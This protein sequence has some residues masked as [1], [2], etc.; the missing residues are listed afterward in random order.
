MGCCGEDNR[1][2]DTTNGFRKT[3]RPRE[4]TDVFWL[5]LFV[6]FWIGLICIATF[7]YIIGNPLRLYY[8]QDSFGNICGIRNNLK[9]VDADV[10]YSGMDMTRRPFVF[11]MDPHNISHSLK[12]CV[13]SCPKETLTSEA[14]LIR[15]EGAYN[16]SYCRYD[17]RYDPNSRPLVVPTPY[18]SP[19]STP[20]DLLK[21]DRDQGYGP[22]PRLPVYES[23]PILKRCIPT[24]FVALGKNFAQGVYAYLNSFDTLKQVVGDLVASQDEIILM[25]VVATIISFLA[26]FMIHLVASLVSYFI[27]LFVSFSLTAV[28]SMLW[29][30]YYDI[31]YPNLTGKP[32]DFL[33]DTVR[34]EKTFLWMSIGSTVITIVL[35]LLCFVMRKRVKLVV[36]LF[37]E[38]GACIRA[39]PAI[40]IQPLWTLFCLIVFLAFWGLVLVSLATADHPGTHDVRL[41]VNARRP[42]SSS[43]T[44]GPSDPQA[45]LYGQA[46]LSILKRV[47][48]DHPSWVTYMWWYL[49]IALF[50]NCEFILSCQQMVIAGA[51]A[52]WYFSR[53]RKNLSCPVGGAIRRLVRYHIGS[54]ALGSFLI[55]LLKL[56]RY[57][58][59][60]IDA[61]LK[62]H[63]EYFLVKGCL[64]C[65]SCCLW[66]VEKFIKYLN[67]NAYT[68]IAIEGSNFCA[69]TQVAFQTIVSNALRVATI[70]SVGDFIL[71]LGKCGVTALTAAIGTYVFKQ[72]D[73]LEF[74]AAPVILTSIVAY[75]IAHSIFSIY[76]MVID[77][78]FLCFC[79]DYNKNDGSPGKEYYAPPSLMAFMTET[80]ANE[81]IA[82][83]DM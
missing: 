81:E 43:F 44:G 53:D 6:L 22:C 5:I 58:I 41:G 4:C 26:V 33:D 29:Y 57:I 47:R 20:S 77:T 55:T 62:N 63:Q 51:V 67:H 1:V 83:Q 10:P 72:N 15:Y 52:S 74:F 75:F 2:F 7:S 13:Q 36:A 30:T 73:K 59:M 65:C 18:S 37:Q 19:S 32:L 78:L 45:I 71:F 40:L 70:N 46:D 3:N 38:A 11:Y 49:I 31:K 21:T 12:I 66:L 39:M 56:P 17:Y 60:T 35:L 28:T 8:G 23:K 25:V 16:V 82:M 80:S 64:K 69:S 68:V 14:D 76:E 27:L 34:T 48:F 9:L 50:W 42:Q 24:N 79:E 54:V 61:K